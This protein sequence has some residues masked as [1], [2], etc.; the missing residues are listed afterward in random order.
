[1]L[2][3]SAFYT[4]VTALPTIRELW[5]CGVAYIPDFIDQTARLSK[6]FRNDGLALR[7][8]NE[9]RYVN[10]EKAIR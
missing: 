1:M 3:V 7:N 5:A 10:S 8:V 9:L 2:F 4:A 6:R